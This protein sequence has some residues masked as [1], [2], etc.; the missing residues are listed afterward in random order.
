MTNLKSLPITI[1]FENEGTRGTR[2]VLDIRTNTI[3]YYDKDC[4][5][6]VLEILSKNFHLTNLQ[7]CEMLD[8]Y[9]LKEN[10]K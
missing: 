9:N 10:Q 1:R 3:I 5:D 8:N 4:F 2:L 7:I 6:D